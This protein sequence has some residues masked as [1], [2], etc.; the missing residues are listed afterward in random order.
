MGSTYLPTQDPAAKGYVTATGQ[1]IQRESQS[2]MQQ[3]TAS[4]GKVLSLG[5]GEV[6]AARLELQKIGVVAQEMSQAATQHKQAAS[7]LRNAGASLMT[8][9]A[10]LIATNGPGA[11][12]GAVLAAQAN[13]H[14]RR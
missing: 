8:A 4:L 6:S 13:Y 3:Q 7:E 2:L 1:A 14:A 11:V 5:T 10:H 12:L 9:S